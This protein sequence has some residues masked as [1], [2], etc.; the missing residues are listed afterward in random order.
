MSE[1]ESIGRLLLISGAGLFALGLI[2]ILA[3]RLSLPF[4]RLPGDVVFQRDHVTVYAPLV[5]CL[6]ASVVFTVLLNLV[7]W[8]LRR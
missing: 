5:S 4:G 7:F 1:F 8:L 3:G 2:L 6:I